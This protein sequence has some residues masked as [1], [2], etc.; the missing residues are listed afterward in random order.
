M[1]RC[2][3]FLHGRYQAKD[4]P[5]YKRLCRGRFTVAV[6]GGY[7]FFRLSRIIPDLLIGDFDSLKTVPRDLSPRTVVERFPAAKDKTDTHLALDYCLERRAPKIDIVQPS[8]GEPDQFMGNLMLLAV[9]L[10]GSG[11]DYWPE[12][13]I[14]NAGYDAALISN[15]TH[16]MSGA[17]GDII[18]VIPL[19]QK[20][21]YSCRGVEYPVTNVLLRQG[22][23]RALRNKITAK[24]A[25][26]D[27]KGQ[28]FV[29]R[30]YASAARQ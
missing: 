7:R 9:P 24:R 22:D 5:F 1:K 28:A 19:S 3:L 4:L 14:V 17:R 2:V 26:F 25:R 30:Q 8:F 20:V 13:R 6:D 16:S 27:I 10:R 11:S 23:T 18:S 29:V 21:K 12:V 15:R